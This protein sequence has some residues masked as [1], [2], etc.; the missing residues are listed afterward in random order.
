MS[1][2][3][4]EKMQNYLLANPPNTTASTNL[5]TNLTAYLKQ[6]VSATA[7]WILLMKNAAGS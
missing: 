7:R 1:S 5:Q 3:I 6:A 2:H 4:N